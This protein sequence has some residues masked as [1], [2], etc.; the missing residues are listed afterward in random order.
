MARKWLKPRIAWEDRFATPGASGLLQGF[1]R[2][3]TALIQQARDGVRGLGD[4]TESIV[5]RGVPWRWTFAFADEGE[6][7]RAWAYLVPQPGRPMLAIPLTAEHVDALPMKRLSKSVRDGIVLA[8]M[9]G[10]VY[11][12]QWELTSRPQVDELIGIARRRR[13]SSA[14]ATA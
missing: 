2:H 3:H 14:A 11:W 1:H 4:V 7:E 8:A 12:A 5:W 13:E 6:P 9:V 10:G